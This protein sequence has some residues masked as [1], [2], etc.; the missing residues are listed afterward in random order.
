MF[1]PIS[2]LVLSALVL[3]SCG[4]VRESRI[5]PFN[6]FGNSISR[7]V[8]DGT[9]A[10]P[11]IPRRN[12]SIFRRNEEDAAYAGSLIGEVSELLVERRPGGAVIRATGVSDM[13]GPFEV[14]LVPVA[15]ETGN[16]VLTYELRGVQVAAARG[17]DWSRTLT[18]AVWLTDAQL[19]EVGVIHVKGARNIRSVRR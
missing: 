12:N 18:A 9:A 2:V 6:W 14:R 10:N 4:T 5:N 17:S 7:P 11:L 8:A 15:A 1:R 3:T 13:Q 16:G 19:A